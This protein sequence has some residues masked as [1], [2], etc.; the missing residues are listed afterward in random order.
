MSKDKQPAPKNPPREK[1]PSLSNEN[2]PHP[3]TSRAIP[4]PSSPLPEDDVEPGLVSRIV[5]RLYGE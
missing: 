1:T 5:R 3:P 4:K 2:L